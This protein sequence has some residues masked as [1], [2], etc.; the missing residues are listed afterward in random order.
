MSKSKQGKHH[1]HQQQQHDEKNGKKDSSHECDDDDDDSEPRSTGAVFA[2]GSKSNQ[3]TLANDEGGNKKRSFDQI[4]VTASSQTLAE[5]HE[6]RREANRLSKRKCRRQKQELIATC[7]KDI[8]RLN[9]E[10]KELS[11][12][13]EKLQKELMDCLLL[14]QQQE[15]AATPSDNGATTNTQEGDERSLDAVGTNLL[16]AAAL[17]TA[18]APIEYS[19]HGINKEDMKPQDDTKRSFSSQLASL[20]AAT[21]SSSSRTLLTREDDD[22]LAHFCPPLDSNGTTTHAL[23]SSMLNQAC[24]K[25][26]QGSNPRLPPPPALINSNIHLALNAANYSLAAA[27]RSNDHGAYLLPLGSGTAIMSNSTSKSPFS[28]SPPGASTSTSMAPVDPLLLLRQMVYNGAA[29]SF[30]SS[31]TTA[32]NNNNLLLRQ[33]LLGTTAAAHDVMPPWTQ[34]IA[35]AAA[36]NSNTINNN[37]SNSWL[38]RLLQ[39]QRDQQEHEDL[40]SLRSSSDRT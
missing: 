11:K 39:Q 30:P 21:A 25:G 10:Y 24:K 12:E 1:H 36:T 32:V 35:T 3:I 8:E 22:I 13:K 40:L 16:H 20:L 7:H 17:A 33:L 34:S 19:N 38:Q 15:D 4:S 6:R 31:S 2:T 28:L 29:S 14:N 9:E 37:N 26:Q 27:D 23:A 5:L 18:E